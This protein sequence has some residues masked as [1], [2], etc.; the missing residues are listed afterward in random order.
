MENQ[1]QP[2]DESTV[3]TVATRTNP[4]NENE[5]IQRLQQRIRRLEE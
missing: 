3:S 1:N 4:E 2:D 5:T